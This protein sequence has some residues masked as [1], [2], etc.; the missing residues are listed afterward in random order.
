MTDSATV[1]AREVKFLSLL[2]EAQLAGCPMTDH[3]ADMLAII[4]S[5]LLGRHYAAGDL[6]NLAAHLQEKIEELT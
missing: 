6:H 5:R 2:V 4:G 1:Y 3:S